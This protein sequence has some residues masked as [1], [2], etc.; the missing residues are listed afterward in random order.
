MPRSELR[1]LTRT[2]FRRGKSRLQSKNESKQNSAK[3]QGEDL[4]VERGKSDSRP[5]RKEQIES[6]RKNPVGKKQEVLILVRGSSSELKERGYLVTRKR[7]GGGG[8][9]VR[10]RT[11]YLSG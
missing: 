9:M 5:G 6:R 3:G 4:A 8:N 7:G 2:K 10:K 11:F 1:V